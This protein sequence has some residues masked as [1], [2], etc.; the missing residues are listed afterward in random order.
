[1]HTLFR[2][3][4]LA[5]L[6]VL[7][8][9]E[10]A[11]AQLQEVHQTVFGMDCAP[12][13]YALERRLGGLDG[14]E[15]VTVSLN[16][17]QAVVQFQNENGVRLDALRAAVRDA[18]FDPRET[19]LRVAGTL[20][21]EEGRWELVTPSGERFHVES[22]VGDAARAALRESAGRRVVV[23]GRVAEGELP[24]SGWSLRGVALAS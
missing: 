9:P 7:L 23:T 24:E 4:A 13:A 5:L 20:R 8:V 17:G 18:G 1:M 21:Q 19:T 10:P 14:A 11:H 22:A 2:L 15:D 16:E 6:T 3:S 12:C